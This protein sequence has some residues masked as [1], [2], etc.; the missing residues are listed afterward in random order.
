MACTVDP[1]GTVSR[2]AAGTVDGMTGYLDAVRERVVV[3]DGATGTNLQLRG[4]TADDFGG[5]ALEGCNELLVV[6]RPDV[7]AELHESFF[8]VGVDVVETDSFGS[9]PWVLAEYGIASRTHELAA[10]SARIA[11]EVASGH[12]GLVA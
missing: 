3:Y 9:L 11:R 2:C 12:G 6:T 5:A 10:A 4:L 1:I 8:A 7:I